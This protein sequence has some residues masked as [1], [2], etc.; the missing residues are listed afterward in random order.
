MRLRYCNTR[1]SYLHRWKAMSIWPASAI[2]M[3]HYHDSLKMNDT[4]NT[5]NSYLHLWKVMS[6]WLASAI[7]MHHYHDRLKMNDTAIHCILYSVYYTVFTCGVTRR[8]SR[9]LCFSTSY[10]PQQ[11]TCCTCL[12]LPL[13]TLACHS[14]LQKS[15]SR[16]SPSLSLS[17]A[18]DQAVS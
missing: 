4:C 3:H 5:R 7:S 2:S 15:L 17:S 12:R 6:I 13:L 10:T 11:E 14:D 18:G 8:R 16:L 9:F 1:N